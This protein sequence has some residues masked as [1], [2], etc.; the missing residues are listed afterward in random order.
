MPYIVN[1][2][3]VVVVNVNNKY[4]SKPLP[5]PKNDLDSVFTHWD[6]KLKCNVSTPNELPN[7]NK[8]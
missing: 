7:S 1:N 3:K 4:S 6:D 5:Y 8:K 2:G